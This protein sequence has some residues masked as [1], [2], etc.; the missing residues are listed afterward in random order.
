MN[1][2]VCHVC[3]NVSSLRMIVGQ[4][5]CREC[6]VSDIR[7]DLDDNFY[8][9]C[10]ANPPYHTKEGDSPFCKYC[11]ISLHTINSKIRE[12]KA[13]VLKKD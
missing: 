9:Q 10:S 6:Y 3:K 5:I 4:D 7:R 11:G 12:F 2:F 13:F 8:H 1:T